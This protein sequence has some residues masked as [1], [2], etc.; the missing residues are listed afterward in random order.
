MAQ[1]TQVSDRILHIRTFQSR[2]AG[3]S[4]AAAGL[5]TLMELTDI[6]EIVRI[7]FQ[8]DVTDAALDAFQIQGRPHGSVNYQ[9]L[10]STAGAFTSPAGLIIGA[11]GDLTTQGA[12]TTGW[13]IMEVRGLRDIRIQASANTNPATVTAVACGG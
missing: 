3:V 10:Y 7:F 4:V 13:F 8:M 6:G 1:E 2:N 9:S 5:T 12:G 11:S